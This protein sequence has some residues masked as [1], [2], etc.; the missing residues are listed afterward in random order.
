VPYPD[1]QLG[2]LGPN[3]ARSQAELGVKKRF[4]RNVIQEVHAVL[5][6]AKE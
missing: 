6:K 4:M 1:L 5:Q 2:G 3:A